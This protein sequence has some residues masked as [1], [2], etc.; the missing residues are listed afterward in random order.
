MVSFKKQY[1][2]PY[3][4]TCICSVWL[5]TCNLSGQ[6]GF[7]ADR[8]LARRQGL[9]QKTA[10]PYICQWSWNTWQVIASR[11][12]VS[13]FPGSPRTAREILYR[14]PSICYSDC[15]CL[16]LLS[17]S[18][19]FLSFILY[20]YSELTIT[21]PFGL[22]FPDDFE[23]LQ[24]SVAENTHCTFKMSLTVSLLILLLVGFLFS[25]F[26]ICPLLFT[27]L[28]LIYNQVSF[29]A[30]ITVCVC[31]W[32]LYLSSREHRLD[33]YPE[34]LAS[35][36]PQGFDVQNTEQQQKADRINDYTQRM[37]LLA[38]IPVH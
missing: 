21:K 10:V 38:R 31:V 2:P 34:T 18:V 30:R 33:H 5:G 9:S 22:D 37:A 16:S 7:Q 17:Q 12:R 11:T 6:R 28:P 24:T 23:Q 15:L 20:F 35:L 1:A 14:E 8:E 3:I 26:L 25:P 29:P 32:L 4:N 19:P 36:C 27:Q 13:V